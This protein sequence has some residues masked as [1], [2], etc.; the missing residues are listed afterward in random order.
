MDHKLGRLEFVMSFLSLSE[1]MGHK[2][3]RLKFGQSQLLLSFSELKDWKDWSLF[4]SQQHHSDSHHEAEEY[5]LHGQDQ[6]KPF[7]CKHDKLDQ[8]IPTGSIVSMAHISISMIQC[9]RACFTSHNKPI[10][11]TQLSV[12]YELFSHRHPDITLCG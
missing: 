8:Y 3:R 9:P 11:L 6:P 1:I 10:S 7:T 2:L 12:N 5:G 4:S